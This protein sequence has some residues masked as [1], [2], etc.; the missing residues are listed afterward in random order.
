MTRAVIVDLTASVELSEAECWP[1]G[2]PDDWTVDDLRQA[3]EAGGSKVNV[4]RDWMLLED[5][6]VVI[7]EDDDGE[8]TEVWA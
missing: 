2:A 8:S 5:I 7:T 3:M 1:D 4:L 6:E